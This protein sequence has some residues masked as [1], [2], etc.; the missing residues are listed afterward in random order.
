MC[1]I[2]DG[3]TLSPKLFLGEELVACY[4]NVGEISVKVNR[5]WLNLAK[6]CKI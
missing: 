4:W 5:S 1:V 3:D 6:G 2:K